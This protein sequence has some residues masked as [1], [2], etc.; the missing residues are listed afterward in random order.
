M[1]PS[2]SAL[3]TTISLAR[4]FPE[5]PSSLAAFTAAFMSDFARAFRMASLL[6]TAQEHASAAKPAMMTS[7][8]TLRFMA[9]SSMTGLS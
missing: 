8:M 9:V 3:R 7:C 5:R 6:G 4:N 2:S 1:S